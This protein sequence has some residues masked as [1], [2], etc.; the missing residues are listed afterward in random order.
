MSTDLLFVVQRF[1]VCY[2]L[3]N[4]KYFIVFCSNIFNVSFIKYLIK[5][6]D[7][8]YFMQV[9]LIGQ[10]TFTVI[11]YAAINIEYNPLMNVSIHL[12]FVV[13]RLLSGGKL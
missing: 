2:S 8:A 4:N 10:N 9:E 7:H 12:M 6:N 3:S 1:L 11:F 5:H 13:W